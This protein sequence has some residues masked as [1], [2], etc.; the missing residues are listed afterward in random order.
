MIELSGIGVVQ[1]VLILRFGHS[2][3][4]RDV[5]RCL[6]VERDSLDFGEVGAQPRENL[7]HTA[8]L[9]QGFERNV[10][11]AVIDRGVTAA[12]ADR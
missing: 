4:Y 7:L 10:N 5:L 1:R 8:A 9:I 6:H 12:G 2:A 3:A 11:A